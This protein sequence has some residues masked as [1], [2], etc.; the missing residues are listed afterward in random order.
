M[1]DFNYTCDKV[2]VET[3]VHSTLISSFENGYEQRRNK[4]ANPLREFKLK[5]E[6]R[7]QAEMED[8][9]DFF[10]SKLGAYSSFTWEN[11][12]DGEEYT[13]RFEKDSL[14]I[15]AIAYQIFSIE[16]RFVEVRS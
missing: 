14:E 8:I 9:R 11:P 16:V 3:I 15:T 5:F 10:L 6:N 13:V 12:N 2:V 7:T 1:A 4:W